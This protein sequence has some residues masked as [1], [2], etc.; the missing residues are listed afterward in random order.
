MGLGACVLGLVD[1]IVMIVKNRVGVECPVDDI[2][3]NACWEYPHMAEGLAIVAVSLMLGVL[4]LFVSSLLPERPPK[5]ADR[6]APLD[7]PQ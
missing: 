1:G 4:I 2:D 6:Y 3:V 7:P 5:Y